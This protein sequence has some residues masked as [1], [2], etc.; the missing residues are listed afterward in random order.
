MRGRGINLQGWI[1]NLRA[2]FPPTHLI[3]GRLYHKREYNVSAAVLTILSHLTFRSSL[4]C[5]ERPI[6]FTL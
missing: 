1:I 2:G 6:R 5:N 4:F 3:G